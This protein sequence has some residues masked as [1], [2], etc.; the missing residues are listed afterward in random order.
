M[1][2][3]DPIKRRLE[4]LDRSLSKPAYARMLDKGGM[5]G[6]KSFLEAASA[7]L[8]G[9]RK[10]SHWKGRPALS[11]RYDTDSGSATEVVI[12]GSPKGLW[13]LAEAG[14]KREGAI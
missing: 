7:T 11:A 8:G 9:D 14:R 12:A 13:I 1:G 10:F 4:S 3:L 2:E 6:K 5:A